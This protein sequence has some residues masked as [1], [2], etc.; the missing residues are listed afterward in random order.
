MYVNENDDLWFDIDDSHPLNQEQWCYSIVFNNEGNIMVSCSGKFLKIWKFQGGNL[1]YDKKRFILKAH[2]QDINTLCYS[3]QT[4]MFV[5]GGDDQ[6]IKIWSLGANNQF[7]QQQALQT[8]SWILSSL[9]KKDDSQL[10][11]GCWDGR[12]LIFQK[13]GNSYS[14]FQNINSHK[15]QIY[16]ISLNNSQ[17]TILTQGWDKKLV[18]FSSQGGNWKEEKSIQLEKNG[19]RASFIDNDQFIYQPLESA[20]TELYQVSYNKN[21][22][23]KNVNLDLPVCQDDKAFFVNQ[24]NEQKGLFSIKINNMVFVM[25]KGNGDQYQKLNTIN[26]QDN[27]IFGTLS[28]NFDYLVAWS[29][30]AKSYKIEK[31]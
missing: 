23:K 12:L 27:Q 11:I 28:P 21:I 9:L 20:S 19:F 2:Q 8:Q 22:E 13:N 16:S 3:K 7:S 31:I 18:I 15:A 26:F 29:K 30:S 24:Y 1:S 4:N 14:E 17:N 6:T 25:K 10:F 5:S